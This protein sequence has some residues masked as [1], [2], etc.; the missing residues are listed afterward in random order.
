MLLPAKA[1]LAA[2]LGREMVNSGHS[3]S[4]MTLLINDRILSGDPLDA[5]MIKFIAST[6]EPDRMA[7]G[8]GSDQHFPNSE[9]VGWSL[10]GGD[11]MRDWV[12]SFNQVADRVTAAVEIDNSMNDLAWALFAIEKEAVSALSTKVDALRVTLLEKLTAALRAHQPVSL[13]NAFTED[14]RSGMSR[15]QLFIKYTGL[16][17]ERHLTGLINDAKLGFADTIIMSAY[18]QFI[19]VAARASDL[20]AE[21]IRSTMTDLGQYID[22]GAA[23]EALMSGLHADVL[24][25]LELSDRVQASL[26]ERLR[27][28]GRLTRQ[29]AAAA[30]SAAFGSR[31]ENPVPPIA[32]TSIGQR[33]LVVVGIKIEKLQWVYG[34]EA[35]R[36]R[37]FV[38][39]D[40]SMQ[41]Y[42]SETDER[43]LTPPKYAWVGPYFHPRDHEWCQCQWL[44]ILVRR[45]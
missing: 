28:L 15:S 29:R 14:L 26:S 19:I 30:L 31:S 45:T 35:T 33:I 17:V 5:W 13:R 41:I 9:R 25:D 39:T 43:L 34:D 4:G 3:A 32:S 12:Q 44:V 22:M 11:D 7:A 6:P 16:D 27:R 23:T 20:T 2:T 8:W 40:F 1:V 21:E 42:E 36:I 18:D 24:I 38:H 10:L 37:P